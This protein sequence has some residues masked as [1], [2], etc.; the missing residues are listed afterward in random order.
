M[1]EKKAKAVEKRKAAELR[2][3]RIP[4]LLVLRNQES[5]GATANWEYLY[6]SN[7]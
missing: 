7:S 4:T 3:L 5:M 1:E 6:S 2:K